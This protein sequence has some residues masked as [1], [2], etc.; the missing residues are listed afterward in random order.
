[1]IERNPLLSFQD[2][3]PDP[4]RPPTV[5]MQAAGLVLDDVDSAHV[6]GGIDLG[7]EHHQSWGLVHG[8]VYAIAIQS[9]TSAGALTAAQ[10]QVWS[11]SVSTTQTSSAR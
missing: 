4:G 9:A 6:T 5:L 11:P 2:P 3:S 1:M 7:A 10:E 8:G